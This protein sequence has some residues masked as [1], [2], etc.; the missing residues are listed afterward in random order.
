MNWKEGATM[1]QVVG[2]LVWASRLLRWKQV[3]TL[4]APRGG[5]SLPVGSVGEA[6]Y[7]GGATVS[8][9]VGDN[10]ENYYPDELERVE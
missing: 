2:E 9:T 4:V 8:V 1:R 10:T 7:H 6:T 3:R 5:L